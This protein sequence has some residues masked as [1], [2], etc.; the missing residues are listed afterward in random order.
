VKDIGSTADLSRQ[1]TVSGQDELAALSSEIN[2]MVES[3]RV[4]SERDHAILASIE[5]G[6]FEMDLKGNLTLF[7]DSL[8]RLFG[9]RQEELI[10]M[11][12]LKLLNLSTVGRAVDAFRELYR[13]GRPITTMETGFDLANVRCI[14]PK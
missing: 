3:V 11:N 12:Y 10:G 6:Y 9:Y 7:N 1:T 5:D 4:S 14:A 13:T 8:S 2:R